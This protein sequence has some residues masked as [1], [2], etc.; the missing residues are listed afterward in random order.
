M[1]IISYSDGKNSL[2]EISDKLEKPFEDIHNLFKL[3]KEKKIL[4]I[5]NE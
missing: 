5:R 2:L 1:D 3:L 4:G